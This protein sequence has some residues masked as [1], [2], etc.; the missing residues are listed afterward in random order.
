M[1][2]WELASETERFVLPWHVWIP[3]LV[4]MWGITLATLAS[5]HECIIVARSLI[6]IGEVVL[7][8]NIE[9]NFFLARG[10]GSFYR[11]LHS[12]DKLGF[13]QNFAYCFLILVHEFE[14]VRKVWGL[15]QLCNFYGR[16]TE[17]VWVIVKGWVGVGVGSCV[18]TALYWL[19]STSFYATWGAQGKIVD[20]LDGLPLESEDNCVFSSE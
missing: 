14:P 18:W 2:F 7:I 16:D 11:M 15:G 5:T 12:P 8:V 1:T 9:T 3:N 17:C 4:Q 6:E 10:F 19:Y 13:Y 20:L